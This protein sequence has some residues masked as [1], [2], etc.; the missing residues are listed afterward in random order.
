M[1]IR[2]GDV[3]K[4]KKQHPCGSY[5]WEVLR[6]G[7]DFRLK[8]EGCGH[9][10]MIPRKQVEKNLRQLIRKEEEGKES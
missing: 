8:C 3:V 4:L 10:I 6:I 5:L 2:V 7:M 1:D 9:Q